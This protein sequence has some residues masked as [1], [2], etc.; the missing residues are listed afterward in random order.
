M[1]ASASCQLLGRHTCIGG[2]A[3]VWG[4]WSSLLLPLLTDPSPRPPR[5]RTGG[6]MIDED[7]RLQ[8][9]HQ[10]RGRVY[11]MLWCNQCH[12]PL[13]L[14]SSSA[15][16]QNVQAPDSHT[17]WAK[18]SVV[19]SPMLGNWICLLILSSPTTPPP[20]FSRY[21]SLMILQIVP[22]NRP[23][24]VGS[25]QY[26]PTSFGDYF[27][28][29]FVLIGTWYVWGGVLEQCSKVLPALLFPLCRWANC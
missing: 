4:G 6:R 9:D 15:I 12:S 17:L 22:D 11:L 26:L 16:F 5:W 21:Y 24:S 19:T 29:F 8:I 1:N 7:V 2:L 25:L 13:G 10:I 14:P 27:S 23:H 20:P 28:L 18:D 3:G